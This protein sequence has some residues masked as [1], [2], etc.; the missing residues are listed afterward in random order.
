MHAHLLGER[1]GGF[2]RCKYAAARRRRHRHCAATGDFRD[3]NKRM[4]VYSLDASHVRPIV[5]LVAAH[6]A[7][8]F[9]T[10][11]WPLAYAACC[12]IPSE[13]VTP[14]FVLGSIVH[15][16]EDLGVGG[17]LLLHA[18]AG[19]VWWRCGAQRGLEL[20]LAYLGAVHTPSHYLR[21]WRRGRRAALA[22]AGAT[23]ALMAW[24]LLRLHRVGTATLS[25]DHPIQKVVIAHVLTEWGVSRANELR[26]C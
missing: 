19:L 12:M 5:A 15:F 22:A 24:W 11:T 8:D 16:S 17:S 7:T 23:T 1:S 2:A 26:L 6:G 4:T 20:M 10:S 25:I 13:C 9:A 14:V 3:H 21:C 18:V